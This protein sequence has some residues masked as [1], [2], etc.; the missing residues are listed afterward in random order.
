MSL[1]AWWRRI[2][3]CR[4]LRGPPTFQRVDI[5]FLCVLANPK[6]KHFCLFVLFTIWVCTVLHFRHLCIVRYSPLP[7]YSPPIRSR[8]APDPFLPTRSSWPVALDPLLHLS[9]VSFLLSYF[10]VSKQE[11]K[12]KSTTSFSLPLSVSPLLLLLWHIGFKLIIR[13]FLLLMTL[14]RAV[15]RPHFSNNRPVSI[16]TRPSQWRRRQRCRLFAPSIKT[17]NSKNA[18]PVIVLD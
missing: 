6:K 9:L 5:V 2:R 13:L 15:N 1:F 17:I 4:Q 12:I 8:S 10:C 18:P 14:W 7:Y 16:S 3:N 11:K